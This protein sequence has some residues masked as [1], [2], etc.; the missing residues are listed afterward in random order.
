MKLKKDMFC[1]L[2]M[3]IQEKIKETHQRIDIH[4][5]QYSSLEVNP[6]DLESNI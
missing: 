2:K 5:G 3:L 1:L 6:K 4:Y